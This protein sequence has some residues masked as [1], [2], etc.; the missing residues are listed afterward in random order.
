[1]KRVLIA[2]GVVMLLV[3]GI[4]GWR[5]T[6]PP[7][8]DEQQIAA[9]LEGIVEAAQA[10]SASGVGGYLSPKFQFD[11]TKK[12]DFQRQL[13]FGLHQ[14]SSV[15]VQTSNVKVTVRGQTATTT[16]SYRLSLKPESNSPPQVYPGNFN[17]QWRQEN[18]QWLVIGAEGNALPELS[19]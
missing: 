16:G 13:V 18:G 19:Q 8:T 10:R 12:G 11:G 15:E 5:A 9:N 3:V 1:M 17:L 4:F 6:H 7:L 2:L 14:Y